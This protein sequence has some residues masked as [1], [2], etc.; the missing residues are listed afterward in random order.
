MAA[1]IGLTL[2]LSTVYNPR[3]SLANTRRR[4]RESS[5]KSVYHDYKILPSQQ[6]IPTSPLIIP[7]ANTHCYKTCNPSKLYV[8]ATLIF[9]VRL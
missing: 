4:A 2:P 1:P 8:I 6:E 3:S 9:K 7:F 5:D